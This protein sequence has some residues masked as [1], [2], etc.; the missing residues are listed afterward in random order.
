ML[1]SNVAFQIAPG[2]LTAQDARIR[3]EDIIVQVDQVGFVHITLAEAIR[4]LKVC[5][6]RSYVYVFTNL[7][8]YVR[9]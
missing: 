5:V 9:E 2:S 8:S 7:L 6:S 4:V 1:S 3:V